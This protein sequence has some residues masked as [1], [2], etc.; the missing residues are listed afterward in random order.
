MSWGKAQTVK[1]GGAQYNRKDCLN[2]NPPTF[3]IVVENL[4]GAPE[5]TNPTS[6][7]EN[8]PTAS[9][10]VEGSYDSYLTTEQVGQY[11]YHGSRRFDC[12]KK[13]PL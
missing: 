12:E 13:G 10:V 8:S 7:T 6:L 3:V 4:S 11:V 9:F 1:K 5:T 2:E